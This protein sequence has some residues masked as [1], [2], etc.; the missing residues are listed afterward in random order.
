[1]PTKAYKVGARVNIIFVLIQH[2]RDESLLKSLVHFFGC[3]Q[4]Y[5]YENHTEYISQS[6]KYNYEKI[7][8]FFR[9]YPVIGVKLQDFEDWEKVAELIKMKAHLTKEGFDHIRQI[10]RGMN[11]GRYVE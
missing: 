1:M 11:K 2:V 3:G 7:L 10:S 4:A 6:F 5:S 9:K 8:P